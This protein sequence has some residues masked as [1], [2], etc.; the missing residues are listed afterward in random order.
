M[1]TLAV[2]G[3]GLATYNWTVFSG[4]LLLYITNLI[5]IALTALVMARLYGF[6]TA[7]SGKQSLFQNFAVIAVVVVLAIPL[8]LSLQAIAFEANAQRIVRAEI[9]EKFDRNS[10]IGALD[11]DFEA[12]PIA[13]KTTVLTPNLRENAE[14]EI[15]RALTTRLRQPVE[16]ALIQ[17]QVGTSA[18]AA[19]QA[20]LSTSRAREEAAELRRAEQLAERLSLVAGVS[21][22]ELTI[23][24][25]RRRAIVRARPLDGATLATYRE[26]E[27]RIAATEPEWSIELTP[28]KLGLPQVS[29]TDGELDQAGIEA[30]QLIAWA[31]RRLN[32]PVEV[33]GPNGQVETVATTLSDAGITVTAVPLRRS[34]VVQARWSQEDQ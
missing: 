20:Q 9:Q 13:V 5:T 8:I 34:N 6:R 32:M 24:R 11:I 10:L 25:Q 16:L 7:L 1:P 28:P 22:D 15:E 33:T 3:F 31:S 23:D 2:V 19:E 21:E 4:A 30:V 18:S 27:L 12:E 29:L 17:N 14:S 26:L